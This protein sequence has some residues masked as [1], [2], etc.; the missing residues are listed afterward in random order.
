MSGPVVVSKTQRIIVEAPSRSVGVVNEGPMGPAGPMGSSNAMTG[1]VRMWAASAVP[2]DWLECTGAA[3]SRTTYV[4]LFNVIGT[5]WGVGDNS[6]TFNIP[7]MRG[8]APIGVGTGTGLTVRALASTVGTETH[9]LTPAQTAVKGHSHTFTGTSSQATSAGSSH[10][11]AFTG[12]AVNSGGPSNNTTSTATTNHYHTLSAHV[13]GQPAHSHEVVQP[14]SNGGTWSRIYGDY[15]GGGSGWAA[16]PSVVGSVQYGT[17]PAYAAD[18]GNQNTYG[19]SPDYTNWAG[20]D[21]SHYMESH[22][23]TTTSSGTNAAEA[24][25]THTLTATGTVSTLADGANGTAHENMQPSL[26]IK[27]IIRT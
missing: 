21:H 22:Y 17:N 24:T 19:P 11:H 23:H 4:N 7:D 5:T 12:S 16:T 3:I 2:N 25:H 13:H 27:F 6:T 15:L 26:A 1:E 8:R 9:A 20:A 18:G 14:G 10:N